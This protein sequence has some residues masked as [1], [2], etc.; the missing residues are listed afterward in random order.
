MGAERHDTITQRLSQLQ[1]LAPSSVQKKERLLTQFLS[2]LAEVGVEVDMDNPWRALGSTTPEDVVGFLSSRD[3][4][5]RTVIHMETCEFL[6]QSTRKREA[7]CACPVRL[8]SDS[9]SNMRGQ[10]QAVFRDRGFGERWDPQR[11]SGNPC[12]SPLVDKYARLS[13]REKLAAGAKP[14]QSALV[15]EPL[16]TCMVLLWRKALFLASREERLLQAVEIARDCLFFCLLWHSGLRASDALRLTVQQLNPL[17]GVPA[18]SGDMLIAVGESKTATMPSEAHGIVVRKTEGP[19]DLARC[20]ARYRKCLAEAGLILSPGKLFRSVVSIDEENRLEWGAPLT[21]GEVDTRFKQWLT[22]WRF[23]LSITPHSFHGSRAAREAQAGVPAETTCANMRWSLAS[24]RHY[25][26]NRA[27][28]RFEVDWSPPVHLGDR[29]SWR[30]ANPGDVMRTFVPAALCEVAHSW[31]GAGGVRRGRP[32]RARSA[33]KAAADAVP[34]PDS[35]QVD[36]D[37]TP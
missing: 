7:R 3:E 28:L 6:G 17:P 37:Y 22:L 23:P 26:D 12:A 35:D 16:F 9:I 36:S 25:V 31:P 32:K 33:P 8:T 19:A 30:A 11:G 13:G 5:A 15:G 10:L 2:Y 20:L 24:Y 27:P 18:S 29:E 21:W 14:V 34:A 1:R 4:H